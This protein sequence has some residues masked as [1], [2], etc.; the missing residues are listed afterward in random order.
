[1]VE[2]KL[3]VF[4]FSKLKKLL[5]HK[6]YFYYV[7]IE[8]LKYYLRGKLVGLNL[9]ETLKFESE[10]G[11]D[12]Y[13][14]RGLIAGAVT[15]I[16]IS[17]ILVILDISEY[18]FLFS[19]PIIVFSS[20]FF[21]MIIK[22]GFISE[23][24]SFPVFYNLC[25]QYPFSEIDGIIKTEVIYQAIHKD[26]YENGEQY[27]NF[28]LGKE[29]L[30]CI[31]TFSSFFKF[32]IHIDSIFLIFRSDDSH[33]CFIDEFKNIFEYG[34]PDWNTPE[35]KEEEYYENLKKTLKR[36]YPCI[37]FANPK[38]NYYYPREHKHVFHK[39]IYSKLPEFLEE[40]RK[41]RAEKTVI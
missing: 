34:C 2:L 26:V 14:Y 28:W 16:L 19:L 24:D 17:T 38:K 20:L 40:K 30:V 12:F 29:W 23:I 11:K 10:T 15:G 39:D 6:N 32:A 25:R 31:D 37:K 9:I 4:L 35:F 41:N 18:I 13:F 36:R 1:M 8:L 22:S 21:G 3:P 5:F 33:I 27:Y 7:I